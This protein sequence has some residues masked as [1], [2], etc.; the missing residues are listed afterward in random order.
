MVWYV[1][2]E[3]L[4]MKK[5]IAELVGTFVLAL[6]VILGVAGRLPIPT[7]I[8]AGLA[9]AVTVYFFGGISGAHVNPAVTIGLFTD[10]KIGFFQAAGYIL[11]QFLGAA[12]ALALARYLIDFQTPLVAVDSMKVFW[13]EGLGAF[14]LV[15]AIT[16]IIHHHDGWTISGALIGMSLVI[17]VVI[18]GSVSNGMLNPAVAFAAGTFSLAYVLGP[19]AGSIVG[20]HSAKFFFKK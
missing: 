18:A 9:I 12:L 17:G 16:M 8:A 10:R 15:F 1:I 20:V 13:A 4:R 19:I 3:I 6:V 11:A 14:L 5:Y 7:A 2:L